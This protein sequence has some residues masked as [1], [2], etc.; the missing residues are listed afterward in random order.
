MVSIAELLRRRMNRSIQEPQSQS[1]DSAEDGSEKES[2]D[3]VSMSSQ[4]LE[5][6][7]DDVFDDEENR[8]DLQNEELVEGA[9][10]LFPELPPIMWMKEKTFNNQQE[11]NQFLSQEGW[12]TRSS[13][14]LNS[15]IKTLYRCDK[16]KKRGLQCQAEVF[17]LHQI[18]VNDDDDD[19]ELPAGNNEANIE[20]NAE[21]LLS[22]LLKT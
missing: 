7:I 13:C 17:V 2:D 1:E 9:P 3:N 12:V 8:I 16:M 4:E 22:Q 15:G 20:Q 6:R 19:D 18:I 21:R 10:V 11:L 14:T 5:Q